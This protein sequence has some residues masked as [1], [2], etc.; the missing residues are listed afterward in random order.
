MTQARVAEM[1]GESATA[2]QPAGAWNHQH[3]TL[4]QGRATFDYCPM[5][6]IISRR[7]RGLAIAP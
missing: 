4:S 7:R 6:E 3:A 1:S 2:R 5:F